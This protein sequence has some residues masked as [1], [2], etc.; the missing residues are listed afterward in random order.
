[1][2]EKS[3]LHPFY[4]NTEARGQQK[5]GPGLSAAQLS[6][7]VK[8]PSQQTG[9]REVGQRVGCFVKRDQRLQGRRE[10]SAPHHREQQDNY[11]PQ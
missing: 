3:V 6:P 11:S 7:P 8:S 10:L 5:N 4:H 1:M 9:Q 2:W